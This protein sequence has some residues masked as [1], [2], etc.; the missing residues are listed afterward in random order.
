MCKCVSMLKKS[1]CLLRYIPDQYKSQQMC[2]KAILEIGETLKSVTDCD[3]NKKISN[4]AV[5]N[6]PQASEFV[7]EC[8]KTLEM[9]GKVLNTHSSTIRMCDKAFNKRFLAVFLCS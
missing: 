2:D 1:P 8:Y 7:P 4:K 3:K 9:C 6:Y 5:D